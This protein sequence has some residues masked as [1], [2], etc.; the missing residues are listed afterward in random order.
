MSIWAAGLNVWHHLRRAAAIS[1]RLSLVLRASVVLLFVLAGSLGPAHASYW[2]AGLAPLGSGN[3]VRCADGFACARINQ[4]AFYG[5]DIIKGDCRYLYAFGQLA[6]AS[7]DG[8]AGYFNGQPIFARPGFA[9]LTCEDGEVHTANG[10]EKKPPADKDRDCHCE[11]GNPVDMRSGRK[12]ETV[13]DYATEGA[14]PL[15]FERYY[16]SDTSYFGSPYAATRL[17]LGWRSNFDS[18][19]Y[20]VGGPPS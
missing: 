11:G 14:N 10:C 8:W 12:V 9:G 17:G 5:P 13:L 7:C 3:G 16:S 6:G 1:C 18:R 20:F 15:K 19:A 2:S 4:E